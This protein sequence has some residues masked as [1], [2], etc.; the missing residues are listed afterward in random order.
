MA[1]ILVG[2]L[3]PTS[4]ET[5]PGLC[6][7]CGDRGLADALLNVALFVP[8]GIGGGRMGLSPFR[9][10]LLGV[11]LS[12]LIETA[13][14]FTPGRDASIGDIIMN[15]G[16]AFVGGLLGPYLETVFRPGP[17]PAK[18]L[19]ILWGTAI[20]AH[21]W[22][23]AALLEPRLPGEPGQLDLY[24]PAPDGGYYDGTILAQR[25]DG[26]PVGSGAIVRWSSGSEASPGRLDLDLESGK[27]R[28][29]YRPFVGLTVPGDMAA[30][31]TLGPV[32]S[33]LV[34]RLKRPIG[35]LRLTPAD[36]W[37]AG[38]LSGLEEGDRF[39]ASV[40]RE[41]ESFCLAIDERTRCGFGFT[42]GSAWAFLV[43][44]GWGNGGLDR[45]LDALW[46]GLLLFP[47]GYWGRGIRIFGGVAVVVIGS[48]AVAPAV[49]QLL[50]A[51]FATLGGIT[52]GLFLGQAGA[53]LVR[54]ATRHNARYQQIP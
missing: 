24:P 22:L 50:A 18:R 51:P 23:L 45:G 1:L 17:D 31:L 20:V 32:N 39:T 35:R 26:A 8:L 43:P 42:V 34:L 40:W 41:G 14:F 33:D 37:Y 15:G 29:S 9:L 38:G 46:L 10:L 11:G 27:F 6:V 5:T 3:L 19:T 4:Y 28:S 2:T 52:A 53:R 48:A 13:Q 16:G 49:S 25:L 44:L 21:I 7:L 54:S 12:G 30:L 47:L 36:L